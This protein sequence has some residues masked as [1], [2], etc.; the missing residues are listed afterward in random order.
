[1]CLIV[2]YYCICGVVARTE[3]VQCSAALA[4]PLPT[5]FEETHQTR[6][7]AMI[8]PRDEWSARQGV[9]TQN[10]CPQNSTSTGT[11][12]LAKCPGC[13]TLCY[14]IASLP[15]GLLAE[16]LELQFQSELK[17][18]T[19]VVDSDKSNSDCDL[20]TELE[21]ELEEQLTELELADFE[22]FEVDVNKAEFLP[23]NLWPRTTAPWS[24][25]P[26]TKNPWLRL[27]RSSLRL[28]KK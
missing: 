9:C 3:Q 5:R 13:S 8:L 23:R 17:A 14:E 2:D 7:I 20:E 6:Q 11:V 16:G 12:N 4:R 25:A 26:L 19:T 21:M 1:M 10:S 22:D 28:S 18:I 15:D 27:A 24:F